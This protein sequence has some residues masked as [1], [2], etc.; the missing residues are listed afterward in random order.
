[1]LSRNKRRHKDTYDK[2]ISIIHT[3]VTTP[4]NVHDVTKIDELRRPDDWEVFSEAGY[5]GMGKRES[6]DPERVSYTAAKRYSQRKKLSEEK[7]AEE[8]VLGSIRCK[9]ETPFIELRFSLD[10]RKSDIER[11]AKN[12][13]RLTMLASIANMFIGNCFENRTKVS[14]D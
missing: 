9:V 14:F 6:A 12:T 11:L 5:L 13:A 10:I 4:A 7:I 2:D 8:K 1:M 3:V